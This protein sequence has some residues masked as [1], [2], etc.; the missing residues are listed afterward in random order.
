MKSPRPVSWPAKAGIHDFAAHSGEK[1]W[2]P[3]FAGMM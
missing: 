1:S 2:I 3:A